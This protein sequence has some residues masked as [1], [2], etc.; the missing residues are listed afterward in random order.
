MGDLFD[1]ERRELAEEYNQQSDRHAI[2]KLGLKVLFWVLFFS[3]SVGETIYQNLAEP[4][5]I[6]DF[7]LIIFIVIVYLIY[8]AVMGAAD[9]Q[10]SYKLSREY[11]LSNQSPD[12]WLQ[13]KLKMFI[14]TSLLLYIMA[15]GFLFCF[16]WL[17]DFW[18]LP[19]T[20]GGIVLIT[21]INFLFPVVL[22]PLF[23]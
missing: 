9:Y 18:W 23:F 15:R 17:P 6:F 22:F 12:E 16:N 10:L 1:Q 3:L 4:I 14:L 5:G 20:I 8:S 11:N 21:V 2:Y 13:D 19:F 7:K